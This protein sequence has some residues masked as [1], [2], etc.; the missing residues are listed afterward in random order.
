MLN[1]KKAVL[2]MIRI[3]IGFSI[4]IAFATLMGVGIARQAAIGGGFSETARETLSENAF[5]VW[6]RTG[7]PVA[8]LALGLAW[9]DR[10]LCRRWGM[11]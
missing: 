10:V 6:L 1:L 2:L 3:G 9:V 4:L 7:G 11:A 5:L 8:A